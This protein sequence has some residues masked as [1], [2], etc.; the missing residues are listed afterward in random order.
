MKKKEKSRKKKVESRF[1]HQD[2]SSIRK[3]QE[4]E[5][6]YLSDINQAS[7]NVIWKPCFCTLAYILNYVSYSEP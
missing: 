2:L 6:R 7:S 4:G 1:Q 3:I 5:T